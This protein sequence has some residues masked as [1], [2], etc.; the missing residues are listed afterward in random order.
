MTTY[1]LHMSPKDVDQ[2][3]ARAVRAEELGYRGFFFAD[4]H[5]NALDA[6]QTAACAARATSTLMFGTAVS[7]VVFRDP[8]VLAGLAA[9][10][11]SISGGRFVLGMGTGDGTTYRLGR[12][13][14]R[15]DDFEAAIVQIRSLLHGGA[16]DG[17]HGPV[18]FQLEGFAPPAV[19]AG[20]EGPRGLR[21]AGRVA[22][23]VILGGGFDL[24]LLDRSLEMIAEGAA[25]VGRSLD[26]LE[27]IG[28]GMVAIDADA[29]AAKDRVRSRIANRAHHNFRHSLASVPEEHVAEVEAFLAGFD[30]T[31]PIDERADPSLIGPYLL[32]RFAIAGDA[33]ECAVRVQQLA[34]RGIHHLMLTPHSRWFDR[35]MEDWAAAMIP[36]AQEQA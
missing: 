7:N 17:P 3:V 12:T 29:E 23:G 31:R 5:L 11:S 15:M 4:S 34:D 14:T 35:T 10:T 33:Q 2:V 21:A 19:V 1:S 25:E 6:F 24:A 26:D 20:V 18:G 22:D 36:T 13:A 32:G 9:S 30:I 8:T 16:V 27:L 28:A